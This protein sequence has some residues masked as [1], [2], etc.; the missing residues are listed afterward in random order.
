MAIQDQLIESQE[1]VDMPSHK[2]ESAV[3]VRDVEMCR[4]DGLLT[5]KSASTSG[6]GQS[7][8]NLNVGR[9]SY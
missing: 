8:R 9:G 1:V 5:T 3:E 7:L 2:I 4:Q 6:L